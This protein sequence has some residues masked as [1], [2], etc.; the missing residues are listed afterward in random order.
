[1][2]ARRGFYELSNLLSKY[3]RKVTLNEIMHIA[4]NEG[5]Y[6]DFIRISKQSIL[7]I[8]DKH[9]EKYTE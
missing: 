2:G 6:P 5:W 4:A 1:M 8:I 3:K 7:K 9:N